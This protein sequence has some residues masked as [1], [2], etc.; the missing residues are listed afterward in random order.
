MPRINK[1]H[2]G[3]FYARVDEVV[4]L[5]LDN[6]NWINNKRPAGLNDLI[7]K[8]YN[9]SKAQAHRYIREA[10]K[11][12]QTVNDFNIEEKRQLAIYERENIILKAKKAGNLRLALDAMKDRD[13]LQGLYTTKIE[14]SFQEIPAI[15]Y[16]PAD[17]SRYRN[18]ADEIEQD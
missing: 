15:V 12:V 11:E 16:V 6:V 13:A 9:V 4:S 17:E 7:Q 2:T 1:D 14:N 18:I 8:K 10:Q 5:L 3:S